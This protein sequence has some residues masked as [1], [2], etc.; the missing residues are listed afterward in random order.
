MTKRAIQSKT[1]WFNILALA[2]I[3]FADQH[4]KDLVGDYSSYLLVAQSMINLALRF[5]TVS[6]IDIKRFKPSQPPKSDQ[7][8]LNDF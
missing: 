5:T 2:S 6:G 1:I 3:I 8:V 4:F 7:S